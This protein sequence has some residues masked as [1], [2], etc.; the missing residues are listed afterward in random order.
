MNELPTEGEQ[1]T[2]DSYT[3]CGQYSGTVEAGVEIVIDCDPLPQAFRYVI[4]RSTDATPEYLC[5]AEVAVYTGSQYYN[6]V[7]FPLA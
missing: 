5:L 1:V 2:A 7:H 4:V 3:L 6:H